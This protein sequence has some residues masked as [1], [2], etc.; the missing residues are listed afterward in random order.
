[1]EKNT[2]QSHAVDGLQV[3]NSNTNSK[4]IW[5]NLPLTNTQNQLAVDTNEVAYLHLYLH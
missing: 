5:M 1:M 2:F 4:K 3:W